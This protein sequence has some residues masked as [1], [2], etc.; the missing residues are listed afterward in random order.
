VL[1]GLAAHLPE[2]DRT[3]VLGEALAAA[4]DLTDE[5]ARAWVVSRGLSSDMVGAAESSRQAHRLLWLGVVRA[6]STHGSASLL[7]DTAALAHWLSAITSRS[8]IGRVLDDLISVGR[9]KW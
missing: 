1:S 5:W 7:G 9:S 2:S 8:E 3:V 4:R 6:A